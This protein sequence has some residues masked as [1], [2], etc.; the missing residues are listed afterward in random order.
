MQGNFIAGSWVEAD[1]AI[2]DVNPSDLNDVVGEYA[3]ASETQADEAIAA[4]TAA[5]PAW[6]AATPGE[7]AVALEAIG[8]ELQARSAELGELLSREEGKPR[9]EGVGEVLRA[10]QI[11]RFFAGEAL[12]VKGEHLRSVRPGVDVDILREPLGV[13]GLITPWNFPIAIPAWKIAPALAYGCTVV[14]KPADARPGIG[15]GARRGREPR[16]VAAG[17]A[18][19]RRGLRRRRGRTSPGRPACSRRLVHRARRRWASA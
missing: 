14:F 4:A 18:Q 19:P 5:G 16:G 2:V 10:S 8:L 17:H 11:F 6:A 3:A 15:V 7:R 9:A 13:V 12:R 1:E